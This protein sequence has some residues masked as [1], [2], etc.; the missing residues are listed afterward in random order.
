MATPVLLLAAFFRLFALHDVPPGLSQDEVLN[1]DIVQIIRS[2]EHALFFREGFGHE[3][4]Y[5]YFSVPFQLLLGDNFLSIRLPA[6][7]LGLLLVALTLRWAKREFNTGT[8]LVAGLGLAISWWPI[9]FSR[10]G[11]RPIMAPVLLLLT[12]WFWRKRPFLAG[13]FLGLSFYS[14]TGARVVFLIPLLFALW[15]FVLRGSGNGIRLHLRSALIVLAVSIAV[16]APLFYVLWADPSLQQRVD[17]LDGPLNALLE[18][19]PQP[20]LQSAMRTMGV[21]SFTG[22]PRWTYTLP[23]RPL[24]DWGTAVF[25]YIGLGIAFWRWKQPRYAYLLIW[26]GVGLLPSAVTPQSPS[27]VRMV[28]ALP[29]VYMLVGLGVTAV[30]SSLTSSSLARKNVLVQVTSSFVLLI[31][32]GINLFRT[33]NDGFTRWPQAETTRLSHYQTVLHDIA[34]NWKASPTENIVVAEAFFEP[35]DRD[36]LIRNLGTDPQARWVQAG[37]DV[38]GALVLPF[39]GN[40]RLYVPEYAPP[41]TELL[42]LAGIDTTPQFRSQTYPSFTTYSLPTIEPTLMKMPPVLFSDSISLIGYEIL[43]SNSE[44]NLVLFTLWRVEKM[45]PAD[46]APFVHLVDGDEKIVAQHDGF[47]AA[48]VTLQAGDLI[49]QRHLLPLERP[50]STENNTIYVGLYQRG[51]NTRWLIADSANARFQLESI[52]FDE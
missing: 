36:S 6:V 50:F 24:F 3:P 7:T 29:V 45:L 9:I 52:F 27:T 48:A 2:G 34:R 10:I 39:G 8:A 42:N 16:A 12:A 28:G 44:D 31:L 4:L 23:D 35:I 32:L 43:P 21:F 25:F 11:I 46:L 5:H 30:F 49:L 51:S 26:L 15:A 14:Y 13:L 47:D 33:V 41:D 37:D 19:A 17:Q 1:A 22:D 20:I 38:A 40:G 18:G